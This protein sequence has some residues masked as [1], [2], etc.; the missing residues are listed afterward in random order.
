MILSVVIGWLPS[1]YF[2]AVDPKANRTDR[3]LRRMSDWLIAI[4]LHQRTLI[5]LNRCFLYTQLFSSINQSSIQARL[6]YIYIYMYISWP[7]SFFL[8]MHRLSLLPYL[9]FSTIH[10]L[11]QLGCWKK[12]E[13]RVGGSIRIR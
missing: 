8:Y 1:C 3:Q 7:N 9:Y 5:Y 2:F 4:S 12:K 6:L 10:I 13:W 11:I